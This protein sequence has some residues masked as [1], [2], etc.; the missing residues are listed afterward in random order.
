MTVLVTGGGGFLGGAIV[1]A[2]VEHGVAVRSFQRS[3]APDLETL[4][5]E[6]VRGDLADPA[7]VGAAVDGC[8]SVFHVAAKAGVWGPR[9]EYERANV[10]GTRNLLDACRRQGVGRLVYTSTPSV[11]HAGGDIAGGNESLPYPERFHAH[12]PRSKAE[13]ER[14]VLA[15]NGPDLATVAL[16]PHLIWGPRDTHLVPQIVDRQRS[17]RLRLVGG[18]SALVD[19]TYIDNAADAHLAAWQRLNLD[20]P[21]AGRAYFISNGDPRPVRELLDGILA[22]AGEPPVKADLSPRIAW[23]V[24]AVMEAAWT[25]LPLPGEP[26]MTRFLARQLATAHWFDLTAARRDLGWSPRIGLDEGFARLA[27]WFRT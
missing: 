8:G 4:G 12:Y 14:M 11:V 5:V 16:R 22:A 24:G 25:V 15:A 23:L 27:E 21:C 7:A 19:S 1:R 3:P 2:L 10:L 26:A 13:A 9:R 17:G 20:A 18:G 6:V